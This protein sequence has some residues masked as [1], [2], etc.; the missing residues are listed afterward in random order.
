MACVLIH[1]NR[2][3]SITDASCRWIDRSAGRLEE[4][5]KPIDELYP[6][7]GAAAS[8]QPLSVAFD[9]KSAFAA[10]MTDLQNCHG[11]GTGALFLL[12]EEDEAVDPLVLLGRPNMEE[13]LCSIECR[14]ADD[15]LEFLRSRL[16]LS[17]DDILRIADVT[18]G[19]ATND[20]WHAARRLIITASDFGAIL[21]FMDR[22]VG[23]PAPSLLKK[24]YER[25]SLDGVRSI[26]W[27]RQ[28]EPRA[29]RLF[30]EQTG[31]EVKKTGLWFDKS[32]ILACSPDGL[33][34]LDQIIEVKCPYRWRNV[35]DLSQVLTENEM[36]IVYCKDGE[37]F[38]NYDHPYYSQ[39]QGQLAFT[40]RRLCN[41]VI[42]V[43]KDVTLYKVEYNEDWASNAVPKLLSFYC[44]HYVPFVWSK[45]PQVSH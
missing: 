30:E 8:F 39:V 43:D 45:S 31:Q 38:L 16:S 11:A 42:Y 4:E 32:G 19:Q 24:L 22:Q 44:H 1:A 12:E 14:E 3:L 27:G 13:L 29:I 2:N 28:N 15:L 7:T 36:Y 35:D 34:G 6:K 20:A 41:L 40:R 37:C 26:M 10:L 17:W 21:K 9:E 23:S 33:V 25:S 5:L 18:I